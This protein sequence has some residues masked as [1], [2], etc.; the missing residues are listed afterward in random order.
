MKMLKHTL[1]QLALSKGHLITST[2]CIALGIA[3]VMIIVNSITE[4][5]RPVAPESNVDRITCLNHIIS[6]D[7]STNNEIFDAFSLGF[8]KQYLQNAKT[9][10]LAS[11]YTTESFPRLAGIRT[12]SFTSI[13]C[14]ASYWQIFDFEFISGHAF[15]QEEFDGKVNV[16]VVSSSFYKSLTAAEQAQSRFEYKGKSYRIVGV[17]KDVSSYRIFTKGDIWIPYSTQNE[18]SVNDMPNGCFSVVYLLK[19]KEDR[20]SLE[21]E[22]AGVEKRYNTTQSNIYSVKISKPRTKLEVL[23]YGDG[24]TENKQVSHFFLRWLGII[25]IILLIPVLNMTIL[26]Y[27]Y[28]KNR[29]V[30][31]G[32]RRSFGATQRSISLL[33]LKENMLVILGGGAIGYALSFLFGLVHQINLFDKERYAEIPLDRVGYPNFTS[34]GIIMIMVLVI[35][36][37]SGLLP[38]IKLARL[39][40]SN[41]LKGGEQ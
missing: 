20:G 13:G 30:E 36:L 6:I 8:V 2:I 27:S 5:I 3:S 18:P 40:V 11:A 41:A 31:M 39:S 33:F 1:R 26:N 17:V 32:V 24:I 16:A 37:L 35:S 7:K 29:Y 23:I 15:T 19:S 38:S 34:F 9:P 25:G 14:D 22:I 21:T 4:Y 28:I 12:K 10:M